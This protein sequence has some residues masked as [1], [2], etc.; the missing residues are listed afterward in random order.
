MCI[1]VYAPTI[2]HAI[3]RDGYR[4]TEMI[5]KRYR[6]KMKAIVYRDRYVISTE[7]S[8]PLRNRLLRLEIRLQTG[9]TVI[10]PKYT[11]S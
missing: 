5:E 2:Q 1:I 7:S 8:S 11:Y 4:N 10:L 6:S 9:F 3:V